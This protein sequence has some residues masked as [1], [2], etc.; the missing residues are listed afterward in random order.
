MS[1][2]TEEIRSKATVYYGDDVCQQQAQRLLRESG[3]P[4]GLLPLHDIEEC[5]HVAETNF[6]WLKQ[7]NK[8]Q[9]KFEK[10]GKLVSY[11]NEVTAY[12]ESGKIKKLTGVKAKELMFWITLV[13]IS[14][15]GVNGDKVNFR[16]IAGPSRTFPFEAFVIDD[17]DGKA[18]KQGHEINGVIAKEADQVAEINGGIAKE[19]DR[20]DEV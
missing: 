6:V 1:L 10:I 5:G 20:V 4:D 19:A 7:K 15:T 9:H 8:T 3:L 13:D 16:S 11:A 18:I 2:I 14:V 17:K 12:A